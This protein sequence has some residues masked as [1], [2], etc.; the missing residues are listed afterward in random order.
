MNPAVI[1]LYLFYYLK[2]MGTSDSKHDYIKLQNKSL[3]HFFFLLTTM[4]S[5]LIREHS[6]SA[7][8]PF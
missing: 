4:K 1:A 3:F 7:L 6:S 2:F 8:I 5:Y